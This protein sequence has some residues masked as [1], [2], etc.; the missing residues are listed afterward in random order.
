[1]PP[2]KAAKKAANNPTK[3]LRRAYEH[4]GRVQTLQALLNDRGGDVATLVKLAKRQSA[5]GEAKSVADLLR[6]AEHLS[7]AALAEPN[8]GAISAEVEAAVE[9]EFEHLQAKAEEHWE[10]EE[11]TPQIAKLY[12][13]SLKKAAQAQ[14]KGAHRMAM[15]LVRAAEALAHV[16]G[17]GG[18]EKRAPKKLAAGSLRELAAS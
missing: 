2:K 9:E 11:A 13:A 7:F 18:A 10:A 16:K 1:M 12:E 4:L 17:G 8:D 6:A 14:A 5:E 15:E 3:D